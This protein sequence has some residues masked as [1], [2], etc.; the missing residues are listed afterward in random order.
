MT[1]AT[2]H[3]HFAD[4][5]GKL[6]LWT[7]VLG[8]PV[9]W[10]VQFQAG[11]AIVR[12]MCDRHGLSALHHAITLATLVVAVGC[13][14]LALR[15]WRRAGEEAEGGAKGG[16]G[17]RSRFLGALGVFTSGLFALT[18]VAEWVPLFFLSPCWY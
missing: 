2:T 12:F 1:H 6:A 11:Y 4:R 15:E 10:A 13:T 9:A 16:V 8:G 7:G 14:L 5:R 17:G 18:I 3:D